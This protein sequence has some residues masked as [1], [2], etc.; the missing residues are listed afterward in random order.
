M[1]SLEKD[2]QDLQSTIDALQEG[3]NFY[4]ALFSLLYLEKQS[5]RDIVICEKLCNI[6]I[7]C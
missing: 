1:S 2:R 5:E 6:T 3:K 7:V 4:H